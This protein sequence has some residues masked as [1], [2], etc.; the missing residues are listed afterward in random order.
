ML[1]GVFVHVW[2]KLKGLSR[3]QNPEKSMFLKL[4]SVW[5]LWGGGGRGRGRDKNKIKLSVQ[6]A[7]SCC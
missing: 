1:E 6:L 7:D 2:L 3:W 5:I 4:V